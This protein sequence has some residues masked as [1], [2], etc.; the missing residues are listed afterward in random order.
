MKLHKEVNH[1]NSESI[2]NFTSFLTDGTNL[3][4]RKCSQNSGAR[5][6]GDFYTILPSDITPRH[7]TNKL[8]PCCLASLNYSRLPSQC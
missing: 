8:T 7:M 2:T 4:E 5:P 6:V 3:S 1:K